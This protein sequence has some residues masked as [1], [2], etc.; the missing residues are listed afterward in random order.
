MKSKEI[1]Q[2]QRAAQIS[3]GMWLMKGSVSEG[4][5]GF[6]VPSFTPLHP[7]SHHHHPMLKHRGPGQIFGKGCIS[8]VCIQLES[9]ALFRIPVPTPWEPTKAVGGLGRWAVVM[10]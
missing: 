3:N 4:T 6:W 8:S 7:P 1:S 5:L 9:D 10:L 2:G